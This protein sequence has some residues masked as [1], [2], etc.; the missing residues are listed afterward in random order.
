MNEPQAPGAPDAPQQPL[1][2]FPCDYPIKVVGRTS[3]SFRARIDA[4]L[5]THV[6][7]LDHSR[8]TERPSAN[9]NFLAITYAVVAVSAAQV[10][11]LVI[12]LKT[13]PDVL[14]VI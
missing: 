2:Q 9:G 8:T 11:A 3:D 13:A 7:D 6:P 14:M 12:D 5:R 1:L 4:I 10:E